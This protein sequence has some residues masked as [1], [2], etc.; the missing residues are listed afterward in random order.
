MTIPE[1]RTI[2]PEPRLCS[3]RERVEPSAADPRAAHAARLIAA[4]VYLDPRFARLDPAVVTQAIEAV[5]SAPGDAAAGSRLDAKA[6][7]ALLTVEV[8]AFRR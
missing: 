7:A 6:A 5:A 8:G 1:D 2:T 4:L 3:T